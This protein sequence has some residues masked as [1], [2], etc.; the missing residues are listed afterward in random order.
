M[1]WTD[2]LAIAVGYKVFCM[3]LKNWANKMKDAVK[4]L[5]PGKHKVKGWVVTIPEKKK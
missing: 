4:D 1:S 3:M 2:I 5:P